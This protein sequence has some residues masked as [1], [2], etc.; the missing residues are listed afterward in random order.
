MFPKITLAAVALVFAIWPF[1]A[2]ATEPASPPSTQ[3]DQQAAKDALSKLLDAGPVEFSTEKTSTFRQFHLTFASTKKGGA[4]SQ[5][6]MR[7]SAVRDGDKVAVIVSFPS[8]IPLYYASR[9]IFVG[10]DPDDPGGLVCHIGGGL[11]KVVFRANQNTGALEARSGYLANGNLPDLCFGLSDI[12]HLLTP[13]I[14]DCTYD[15]KAHVIILRTENIV[16]E[17]LLHSGNEPI[18]A[19]ISALTLRSANAVTS[20]K[21]LDT[22]LPH[23]AFFAID[24]TSVDQLPVKVRYVPAAT[25]QSYAPTQV[26]DKDPRRHAA[27]VALASLLPSPYAAPGDNPR[28]G[29]STR[30]SGPVEE[31]RDGIPRARRLVDSGGTEL[32]TER[33]SAAAKFF[34]DYQLHALN[35]FSDVYVARDGD[36]IALLACDQNGLPFAYLRNGLFVGLDGAEAKLVLNNVGNPQFSLGRT[37]NLKGGGLELDFTN[38]PAAI[39]FDVSSLLDAML[40]DTEWA[41]FDP[42]RGILGLRTETIASGF[43]LP[44]AGKPAPFPFKEWHVLDSGGGFQMDVTDIRVNA[45]PRVEMLGI[46]EADVRKLGLPVRAAAPGEKLQFLPIKPLTEAQ[47]AAS[48]KLLT[49]IHENAER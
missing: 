37:A 31:D 46:T 4:G 34:F 33:T 10:L 1:A 13:D 42:D 27:F 32:S 47:K 35:W 21:V 18:Q 30:A 49:L 28:T 3:G 23:P 36:R 26:D 9:D 44:T 5:S 22:G 40:P 48:L 17:V 45:P 6:G 12:L 7:A 38:K 25:V 24:K 41:T 15:E 11:P 39:W 2:L 19:G 20:V 8:G 16:T 14:R 43:V 29:A